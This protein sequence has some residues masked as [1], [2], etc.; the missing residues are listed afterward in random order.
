MIHLFDFESTDKPWGNIDDGV[1]G[2]VSA[3][4]MRI[5]DGVAVF[6]G[7]LSL[8]NNGGFASVRSEV[9]PQNLAGCE[10]IR[11]RIQGDGKV[12]QFRIRTTAAF[13]GPSYQMRFET[14][15]D[16]FIE[17]DL[18]FSGFTAVFR[19]RPLPDHPK[20]DP[21]KIATLGFMISE[22]QEGPF[23]L[24]VD[25]IRAFRAKE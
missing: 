20:L 10:G 21:A 8:E 18:P 14:K 15:K 9:L 19:G 23:T 11:L 17:V 5:S 1:M 22:K 12:Y 24:K 3:S 6:E 25:W 4:R 2:G 7:T 13:D 16:E